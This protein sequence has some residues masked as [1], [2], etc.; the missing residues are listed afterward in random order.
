ME[1][2]LEIWK[3]GNLDLE[4]QQIWNGGPA[5]RSSFFAQ[6]QKKSKNQP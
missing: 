6:S 3:S 4:G 1:R 2:N 5:N